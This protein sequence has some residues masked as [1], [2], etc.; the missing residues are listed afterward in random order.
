[1]N[2]FYDENMPFAAEFFADLG[3]LTPFSGRDLSAADISDADVLLVRSIT[4]VNEALLQDN[5]NLSFVGTATIGVDHIDQDYLAERG[6]NF[7][8]APGCN[9]VS[10]AEYV[11][12]ALVVLAERY[13]ITLS[14]LTVGIVGA[15]NTGSRLSEKLT[16]LNIKHVLCDPLLA[17]N[18]ADKRNFVEL[19]QALN[20]DVV[21]LHVPLTRTGPHATYHLLDAGRLA[22]FKANQILINACRGEVIDNAALLKIKQQ[23]HTLKLVLDVWENEPKILSALI[24][25][26]D[27]S[28]AHIAGYSLEGKAR[29]TEIL[30]RALCRQLDIL[31]NKQLADFLPI[32]AIGTIEIKQEFDEILLNQL[33]K[34]VYDVRRDDAI[35]RQQIK[36]QGFDHIRKTYPTRREFSSI[37]VNLNNALSLDVP[38]QLGFNK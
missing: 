14:G 13:L 17:E 20:C 5:K 3:V 9:A 2:I 35:F 21:S 37:T 22:Q 24:A 12:S 27:I 26:C 4:K 18:S 25:Y 6:V 29:G 30:Y 38:H 33:V 28:T 10:V 8:S 31:P 16:A 15:G 1:M 23:G 32:S 19:E 7:Y 36:L 34:M 11:L